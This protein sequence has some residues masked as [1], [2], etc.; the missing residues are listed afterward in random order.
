VRIVVNV[1]LEEG[2]SFA[3]TPDAGATQV[4]AA[5][6]GNPTN[7]SCDLY[8]VAPTQPGHAGTDPAPPAV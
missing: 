6:G 1:Q 8:L 3:Y 2:D 5:L 7:D 4:L